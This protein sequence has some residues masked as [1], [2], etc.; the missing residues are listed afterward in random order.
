MDDRRMGGQE[1]GRQ[2][3]GRQEDGSTG[4][5]KTGGWED[6]R[7]ED[8]RMG[9]LGGRVN[10]LGQEQRT[11]ERWRLYCWLIK[12]TINNKQ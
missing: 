1:D 3:D 5:W 4:G 11:W 8:R 12:E 6:R 7:L 2:E 10:E 9:G